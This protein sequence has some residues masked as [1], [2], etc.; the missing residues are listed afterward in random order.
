MRMRLG[1]RQLQSSESQLL[2]ANGRTHSFSSSGIGTEFFAHR[3]KIEL[4]SHGL[5][6]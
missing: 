3:E 6:T 4:A 5:N 2:G 1:G